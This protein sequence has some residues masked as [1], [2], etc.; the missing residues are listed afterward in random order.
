[1]TELFSQDENG[2]YWLTFGEQVIFPIPF[3]AISSNIPQILN[4]F[5]VEKITY[6]EASDTKAAFFQGFEKHCT[7][8]YQQ[9]QQQTCLCERRL[10]VGPRCNGQESA[11]SR[12]E[13]LHFFGTTSHSCLWIVSP[14]ENRGQAF[15]VDANIGPIASSFIS[16]EIWHQLWSESSPSR[17]FAPFQTVETNQDDC[18]FVC[19]QRIPDPRLSYSCHGPFID[20][21][22][23]MVF[24]FYLKR[25]VPRAV[26]HF[27]ETGQ[28]LRCQIFIVNYGIEE[29]NGLWVQEYA[30]TLS[31][32]FK[33]ELLK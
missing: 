26:V 7:H 33:L 27:S 30:S 5:G 6:N 32:K 11:L 22:M 2:G 1:M 24:T 31:S 3:G 29:D 16:E 12:R 20:T 9:Q 13:F 15:H 23:L 4:F 18:A 21:I 19:R 25:I 28:V 8:S 14:S 17:F 10:Y